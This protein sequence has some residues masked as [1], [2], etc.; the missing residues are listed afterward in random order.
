[1]AIYLE[2][3]SVGSTLLKKIGFTD[4][5]FRS[6]SDPNTPPTLAHPLQKSLY[7]SDSTKKIIIRAYT[8][9]ESAHSPYVG[10]EHLAH[11]LLQSKDTDIEACL[12]VIKKHSSLMKTGVSE[13]PAFPTE[14]L[15]FS[16]F[17]NLPEFNL[18]H[19]PAEQENASAIDQFCINLAER[20]SSESPD[21]H[22][23]RDK[24]LEKLIYI[25]GRKKKNNA[26]LLGEPGVG[27]TAL[28]SGLMHR[29]LIGSVPESLRKTVIYELDLAAVV[30][31]TSFRGEFEERLKAI[32]EEA[33]QNP[34]ILLFID[35]I[36][37]IVGAG[38]GNGSLDAANILKPAL[39]RGTLRC[40]G[41]TTL[42]EF[43]RHFEKDAALNR[44]FQT[45][46]IEEPSLKETRDILL[47]M[48]P[49]F[50]A[51][52]RVHIEKKAITATI[53]L[54]ARY[55]PEK[56]FP[57]K[58]LDII[59][60]ACSMKRAQQPPHA[61]DASIRIMEQKLSRLLEKKQKSLE[62]E[63]YAQA[64]KL[65]KK[66]KSLSLQIKKMKEKKKENEQTL[67][68]T[69]E[70]VENAVA[71]NTEI[72]L[73]VIHANVPIR[74]H[75]LHQRLLKTVIGQQKTITRIIR[76]L[77]RSSLGISQSNRPL[78]SFLLLGPT[79]VGKTLTAKTIA[80]YFFPKKS[81]FIRIDM[82]EFH[83]RHTLSGLLG[84]PAGYV[85]YGEGGTLTEKI[86]RNPYSL[87]LFD[88]VEKA[89]PDILNI[90]LQILEE[91]ELTDAEGRKVSFSETIIILTA[92]IGSNDLFAPSAL[93]F[94][95]HDENIIDKKKFRTVRS[96]LLRQLPDHIRPEIL[97]RLDEV[98]ILEPLDKTDLERILLLEL[99]RI[100]KILEKKK[101]TL[102]WDKKSIALLA[103]KSLQKNQ[104]ARP[105]KKM[106]QT[107]IENAITEVLLHKNPPFTMKI[108]SSDKKT[109]S[110]EVV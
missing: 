83:E 29:I 8:L 93:G 3:G 11:A 63:E 14:P 40:I 37:T 21:P 102:L 22:I 78:G 107:K 62:K 41:A 84:A 82:S 64:E 45:I 20:A 13:E 97:A 74:L 10:T 46:L 7:F 39:A 108:T 53:A 105:L 109:L 66:E 85:G 24:E 19:H 95:A 35:E 87:V 94:D 44:R 17:L 96:R 30:A 36:H 69:S 6:P 9:A 51:F 76:T 38:N 55:L 15:P 104:G 18:L 99:H 92:N 101:L 43:K 89:H 58:A 91:G 72:P 75:N 59:D 100:K 1:M 88:E 70:D 4:T 57:D 49:S 26:L 42:K 34:H 52:H 48:I 103:R 68:I 16:H 31:G 67:S 54:S 86:R 32:I 61:L 65:Q 23:G 98:L 81:S 73:D 79:G 90:L 80:R 5:L 28:V 12:R 50:E 33:S 25:L 60:S 47:G 77:M 2:R 27:K 56:S 106:L 71:Q 110:C